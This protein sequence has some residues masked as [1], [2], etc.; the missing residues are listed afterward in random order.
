MKINRKMIVCILFL[1]TLIKLQLF[2]ADIHISGFVKDSKTSEVLIGANVWSE[3]QKV[4]ISTDNKGYFSMKVQTPCLLNVSY[5]GYQ[6]K[7]IRIASTKDTLLVLRMQP[8]NNL[9]EVVVTA[10]RDTKFGV[11]R[12]SAKELQLVP[13]IGGKPDVLKAL[14]LLPGVQTQSEGMSLMLVRGGDPGQNL[15]LVDNVPLIYVNHL[16]GFSSV[17]NPD[18]I[19]SVE[20][21]KG[22]FPARQGGKLSSIVDITQ[23]EGNMSKQQGSFSLGV[24]DATFTLEGPLANK[25]MSYIVTAR[26]TLVDAFMALVSMNSPESAGILAYGFHDI[27]AKLTWKPNEKNNLNLNIYQGD[28]YLNFWSKKDPTPLNEKNHIAQQW[29]NWLISGHWSREINSKLYAENILSFS[30]YQSS[31]SQQYSYNSNAVKQEQNTI[32][33]SSVLDLSWRTAWKYAF[34]RKWNMEFGG[35]LS[36]LT[37]EPSYYYQSNA[38]IPLKQLYNSVEGALFLE[39]KID[40]LPNLLFQPSLRFASY[41]NDGTNFMNLE[42]RVSLTYNASPTQSLNLNYMSVTQNSHLVFAIGPIFKKE[43]WLPATNNIPPER[44]QQVSFGWNSSYYK[45]KYNTELSVYYK[46]MTN[47]AALKEG[48]E[49]MLGIA[50]IDNKME[51]G[52]TGITYGAEFLLRKNTGKWTGCLSYAWSVA[53]RQFANINGGETYP[54]DYNRPHSI[55]LNINKQLKKEWTMSVVWIFQTGIPYTPA[56]GKQYVLDVDNGH[57][58]DT[59]LIYGNKNSA[60]MVDYH[61]LDLGFNH[62]IITR[63]GRRAVWTYSIYNAYNRFNPYN[64][65]YENDNHTNNGVTFSKPLNLYKISLFS[66][67]PSISYKLFFDCKENRRLPK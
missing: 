56:L 17:F 62:N 43:I 18:M 26:K 51:T 19:N 67:I 5:V 47:L 8:E 29:G 53:N 34:L 3:V 33:R 4:G 61:R 11:S 35:Q 50:G 44:S 9:D 52:G 2:G 22:N 42:P 32:N 30:Q 54:Y 10:L 65:Y 55:T 63:H 27:N 40:L 25:K 23:R 7:Q 46:R 49:N 64:Y 45:G 41:V 13:T 1:T 57:K 66:I 38:G 39:N 16:G 58:I 15:Y 21:Y 20:L 14:Q 48:Y 6:S 28:D 31:L 36:S 37:Y 24:M 59:Y 60:R 12:L